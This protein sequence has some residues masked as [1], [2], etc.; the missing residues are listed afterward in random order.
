MSR[1]RAVRWGAIALAVCAA[2]F[3]AGKVSILLIEKEANLGLASGNLRQ[4]SLAW[5]AYEEE[6][7]GNSPASIQDLIDAELLDI[8]VFEYNGKPTC[9]AKELPKFVFS[10]RGNGRE[11][12]KPYVLARQLWSDR[13]ELVLYSNGTVERK[14]PGSAAN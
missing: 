12:G 3:F 1:S 14:T 7:E 5:R 2:L 6:K 8:N 11:T 4:L 10:D 13:I 9:R